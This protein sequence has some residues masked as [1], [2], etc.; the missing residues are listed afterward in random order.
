MVNELKVSG[1]SVRY[2]GRSERAIDEVS[3]EVP[4][5]QIVALAGRTGSGK[6]TLCLAS[7]GLVPRVVRAAVSG[8]VRLGDG[9]YQVEATKASAAELGGR[10]GIVFSTPAL[11][12]SASKPTV[13]EELAFGLENLGTPRSEMDDR[14]DA[15][16][17]RLGVSHL[18][19]R[20]PLTLSGGEQQRVAIAAIAVMGTGVVV[21][22]EPTAQLDPQGTADITALLKEM[23]ADGRA[24][25]V[26]E[27][28]DDVLGAVASC[29]VLDGGRVVA[30][31][32]PGDVLG[33][34]EAI[35]MGIEPPTVVALAKAAGVPASRAFDEAEVAAALMRALSEGKGLA[36]T[37][38]G[39]EPEQQLLLQNVR[40]PAPAQIDL[41]RVSHTYAGGVEAVRGVSLAISAGESVAI[42]GQNGSGK[43]TLV[44]HL[45]GLLRP[46]AGQVLVGGMDTSQYLVS[47]LAQTVGF[48]FQDPDDQLFNSRVDREVAFGPRNMRFPANQTNT[49]VEEALRLTGLGDEVQT[50][51]YDLDLSTRKLVALAGV[52][53][54]EPPVLVLD[55]PTM[56]QDSPGKHRIGSIIR[57]WKGIGRTVVTISHDMEFVARNFDRVVVMRKGEI[58]LDGA[59]ADVFAPGNVAALESTGLR[60]PPTSRIAALMGHTEVPLRPSE[61]MDLLRPI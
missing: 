34:P 4:G 60:P 2:L 36:P 52:L 45:N 44:K 59:P 46:T 11:Q 57:A 18:A 3:L 30:R 26:A 32:L 29:L 1:L 5:G 58:I 31:G 28:A 37:A 21:L 61:L 40:N 12:L 53:A 22:D 23:A 10:V 16:M 39:H 35:S 7:S 24:V 47:D 6:S 9:D 20:E 25:L 8:S 19:D 50:N 49:L 15:A 48:V 55:E 13:R 27:H 33:T 41:H 56:G 43:S 54:T 38:G 14:I 51:P 42:I 17:S